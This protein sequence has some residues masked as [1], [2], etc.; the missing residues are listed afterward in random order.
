M[1]KDLRGFK[2]EVVSFATKYGVAYI[3]SRRFEGPEKGAEG[4]WNPNDSSVIWVAEE[5]FESPDDTTWPIIVAHEIGHV[6]D[7]R[8]YHDEESDS[9]LRRPVDAERAADQYMLDMATQY[10]YEAE[11]K[12]ILLK[13][14]RTF[15]EWNDEWQRLHDAILAKVAKP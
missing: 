5:Y 8:Q 7:W 3:R 10:G 12:R 1:Q 6:I 11:A 9:Y 13:H 4:C 2:E 15:E 14:E